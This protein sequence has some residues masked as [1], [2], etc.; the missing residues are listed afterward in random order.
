MHKHQLISIP[1]S[2][3]CERARWAL[4]YADISFTEHKWPPMLHY[5][6][7]F[8]AS[9]TRTVPVLKCPAS[10][11]RKACVLTDSK[12][13]VSYANERILEAASPFKCPQALPNDNSQQTGNPPTPPL[14]P[15]YPSDPDQLCEV[16]RLEELFASKLG[17]WTRVVAYH[18]LFADRDLALDVLALG[19]QQP[20]ALAGWKAALLQRCFPLVRGAI[21]KGLRVDERGAAT[22]LERIKTLFGELV[23]CD[24]RTSE[25]R[26]VE[27]R[28]DR[29]SGQTHA[30]KNNSA[31]LFVLSV[32]GMLERGGG[33]Y[34][35]GDQFTAAD[36][37]FAA[38]VA[39]VLMPEQY[40]AYLGPLDAWPQE[41]PF[42]ELRDTAAG[43]HALRMYAVHRRVNCWGQCVG[44]A[45]NGE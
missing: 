32:G 34:L 13:I 40:G 8:P 17:V 2:H 25:G 11:T 41:L 21:C 45:V 36:L 24:T 37:T 42:R 10:S 12:D 44:W 19:Q 29:P 22:C 20:P 3:Y 27:G 9:G 7:A 31:N 30:Y 18:H 15:L 26:A 5:F 38:M 4:D 1:A 14:S 16:Q 33:R 28:A 23:L 43:R 39:I 6:G 35:V